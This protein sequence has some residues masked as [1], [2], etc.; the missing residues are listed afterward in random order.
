MVEMETEDRETE[1]TK[2]QEMEVAEKKE[3]E[4]GC[5]FFSSLPHQVF[6]SNGCTPGSVG[7]AVRM[8]GEHK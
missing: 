4:D 1:E 7:G 3:K 6:S 2:K 5:S 8:T